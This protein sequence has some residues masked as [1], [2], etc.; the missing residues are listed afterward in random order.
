M[1]NKK[2]ITKK[3]SHLLH[4]K[5]RNRCDIIVPVTDPPPRFLTYSKSLRI[6]ATTKRR[7]SVTIVFVVTSISTKDNI[8]VADNHAY[9][10]KHLKLA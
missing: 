5:I 9:N 10:Y 7:N 2:T 4:Y 8:N 1:K 6:K 3:N